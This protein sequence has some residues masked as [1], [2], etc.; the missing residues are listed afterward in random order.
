MLYFKN[1]YSD[2]EFNQVQFMYNKGRRSQRY[3]TLLPFERLPN[4]YNNKVGIT[5][6]KKKD[7][8]KL[9]SKL[10]IPIMHHNYYNNLAVRKD[11][12]NR[13]FL[14]KRMIISKRANGC[15]DTNCLNCCLS[16]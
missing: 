1:N 13:H 15:L 2:P 16:Q 5:D 9:C 4:L 12:V 6:K 10:L 11:S 14:L 3:L 7:L 8:Q